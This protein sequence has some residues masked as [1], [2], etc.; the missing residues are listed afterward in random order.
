MGLELFGDRVIQCTDLGVQGAQQGDESLCG[1]CVDL[2]VD[3]GVEVGSATRGSDQT[4][5]QDLGCDLPE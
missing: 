5:V 2:D 4:P 3:L 1:D